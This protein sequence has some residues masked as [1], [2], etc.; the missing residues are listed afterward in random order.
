[1][2]DQILPLITSE[3]IKSTP[4]TRAKSEKLTDVDTNTIYSRF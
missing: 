1:M 3:E 4:T 2:V